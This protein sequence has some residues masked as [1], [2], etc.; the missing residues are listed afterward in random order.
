L[1][2][3]AESANLESIS[4]CSK[5]PTHSHNKEITLQQMAGGIFCFNYPVATGLV[6]GGVFGR[7][8][9]DAAGTAVRA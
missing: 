5:H 8:A 9:G 1:L 6:S 3:T 2:D 7:I 4:L